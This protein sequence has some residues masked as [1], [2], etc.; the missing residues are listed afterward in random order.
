MRM[1]YGDYIIFVDESGDHSL[2]KVDP[3][4]PVFV[5]AFCII[6]KRAYTRDVVPRIHELKFRWFGHDEVVLHEM[7]IRKARSPFV[8]LGDPA[9]K[10]AFMD[11]LSSIMRDAPMTVVAAVIRKERLVARYAEPLNP[12]GLGLLFCMERSLGLLAE[13][14]QAGRLT[15]IVAE[16]RSPRRNGG[17]GPED[18]ELLDEFERIAGGRHLLRPSE[19]LEGF[20]L[21]IADKKTNSPGLQLADLVARPIGTKTLRPD[22]PNRAFDVLESKLIRKIFP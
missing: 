10:S 18:R 21:L 15:H 6:E 5:L 3:Q 2:T 13:R 4:Y 7:D 14:G 9:K 12:Y 16:A 22:Q 11:E 8:F 19:P 17:A 20:G 1:E